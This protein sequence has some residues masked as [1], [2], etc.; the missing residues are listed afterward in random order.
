M[1]A[2]ITVVEDREELVVGAERPDAGIERSMIGERISDPIERRHRHAL[3]EIVEHRTD[4]M[5]VALEDR[6]ESASEQCLARQP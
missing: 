3:V 1:S 5:A 4:R 6:E 2:P